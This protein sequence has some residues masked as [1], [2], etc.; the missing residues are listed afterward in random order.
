[1]N[2]AAGDR[3][4]HT[5]ADLGL[6]GEPVG[7]DRRRERADHRP[8]RLL[9]GVQPRRRDQPRRDLVHADVRARPLGG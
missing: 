1:M 9:V 8:H 7:G 4:K 2:A 3:R 6:V 5:A